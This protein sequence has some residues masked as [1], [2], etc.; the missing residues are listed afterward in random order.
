MVE[1]R[2]GE[3]GGGTAQERTVDIRGGMG[4]YSVLQTEKEHS[5]M[6]NSPAEL[7]VALLG[8]QVGDALPQRSGGRPAVVGRLADDLGHVGG[9]LSVLNVSDVD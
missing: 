9:G 4:K 6:E 5:L 8:L 7:A 1:E 2:R 3:G